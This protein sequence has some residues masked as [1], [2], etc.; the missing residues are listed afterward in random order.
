MT[1]RII[2]RGEGG[3]VFEMD[4]PLSPPIQ[5]RYEAG[6]LVEVTPPAGE[7]KLAPKRTRK[8]AAGSD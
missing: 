1:G 4:L 5:S 2:L 3:A 6:D 7:G 8:P